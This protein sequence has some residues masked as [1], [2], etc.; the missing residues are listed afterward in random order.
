MHPEKVEKEKFRK[1]LKLRKWKENN[2][3]M[4]KAQT[5]LVPCARPHN[6]HVHYMTT[7]AT[8]KVEI[9]PNA[10]LQFLKK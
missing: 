3:K 4:K 6:G 2:R 10:K 5:M 7:G 1:C 8:Y 9:V